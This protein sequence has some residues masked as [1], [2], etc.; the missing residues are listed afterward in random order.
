M[1]DYISLFLSFSDFVFGFCF[2][3][4]FKYGICRFGVLFLRFESINEG[5]RGGL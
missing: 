4:C 5:G 3:I 2:M 1:F